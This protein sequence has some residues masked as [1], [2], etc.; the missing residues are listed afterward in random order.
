MGVISSSS[1]S[2]IASSISKVSINERRHGEEQ[3]EIS[4]H[5]RSHKSKAASI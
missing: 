1:S 4:E 3:W 5:S 2:S